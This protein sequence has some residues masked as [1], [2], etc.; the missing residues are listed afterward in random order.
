MAS[1]ALFERLRAL[2]EPRPGEA[3][4]IQRFEIFD[5]AR[6]TARFHGVGLAEVALRHLPQAYAA[7][8]PVHAL[9]AE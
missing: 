1:S 6:I 9:G 7:L 4:L 3:P 8:R 5:A 2:A